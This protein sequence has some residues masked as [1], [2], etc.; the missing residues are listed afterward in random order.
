MAPGNAA[1]AQLGLQDGAENQGGPTVLLTHHSDIA[2]PEFTAK[3]H[4]NT[5]ATAKKLAA[6]YRGL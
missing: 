6:E 2:E 1:G 5:V 3:I 4:R